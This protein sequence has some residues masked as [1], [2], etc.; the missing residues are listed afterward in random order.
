MMQRIGGHDEIVAAFKQRRRKPEG[1]IAL[2]ELCAGH[3]SFCEPEHPLRKI[4]PVYA[5]AP[6][7]KLCRERRG[8]EADIQHGRPGSIHYN[9][10]D[11]PQHP[12]IARKGIGVRLVGEADGG[13]VTVRPQI[14]ARV[15]QHGSS[16]IKILPGPGAKD[17]RTR[18][19]LK[20][21]PARRPLYIQVYHISR[22]ITI[23]KARPRA[24]R[25]RRKNVK[26]RAFSAHFGGKYTQILHF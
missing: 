26:T 5:A 11:L 18:P 1:E 20:S 19:M 6:L 2:I 8:A 4:L 23:P 25:L 15:V 17:R 21:A 3:L 22:R 12:L 24:G 13:V 16:D 14:E 7:V 9:M 10:K